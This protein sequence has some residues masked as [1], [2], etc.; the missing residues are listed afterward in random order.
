MKN[1]NKV[2]FFL[3]GS[4]ISILPVSLKSQSNQYLHFD[5]M[6]DYVRLDSSSQY[7]S[8]AFAFSM[9]GWFY[10]D[11]LAYGQ[12]MIGFR[13]VNEGFYLIQ[14]NN[15][16]LECR[17]QSSTGLHEF[18]APSF[19]ILPGV[20]QHIAWVYDG[21][22]VV[23]YINGIANGSSPASGTFSDNNIPFTIGRSILGNLNFY[24]GGRVDEVSVWTKALTPDDIK[25]MMV[26]ELNG[27]EGDL[28][29]YYKFNQGIPG[30]DNTSITT[31]KCEV[32][33]GERDAN[34]IG[35]ALMGETSNFNGSVISSI[36][37]ESQSPKLLYKVFPNPSADIFNITFPEPVKELEIGVY[38]G[39]GQRIK[40]F[41]QKNPVKTQILDLSGF[42]SGAYQIEVRTEKGQD[43]RKLIKN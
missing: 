34:L 5:R 11:Q 20:W 21:S 35:F 23:L 32:G 42:P 38:N 16:M 19:S 1:I 18:V 7:I 4:V 12:G 2:L 43:L 31:L 36:E 24:Y 37:D 10:T 25:N 9:A 14:L 41:L 27:D 3:L 15:G 30:E 40:Y 29:L 17:F 6:D 39:L 28:Q 22:K 26:N 13:G 8:G 33:D